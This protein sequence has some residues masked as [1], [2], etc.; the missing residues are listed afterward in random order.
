[1]GDIRIIGTCVRTGISLGT[2]ITKNEESEEQ[3]DYG[4]GCAEGAV[5]G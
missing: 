5:R 4:N 1:L 2:N 3:S